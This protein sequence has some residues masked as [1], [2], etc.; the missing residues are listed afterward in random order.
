MSRSVPGIG[1]ALLATIAVAR[2]ESPQAP[3]PRAIPI[4]ELVRQLG[5]EDF[6]ERE[7]AAKRLGSLA[8]DPPSE[9]LAAA[10]SDIPEVRQRAIQ[11]TQAMRANLAATRLPRG[12]RFAEVGRVDLFVAATAEWNL[13]PEDPRLWEPAVDLGRR[14][15]TKADMKGDRKP[16]NCPSSFKDFATYKRFYGPRFTRAGEPYVCPDPQQEDPPRLLLNEAILAPGVVSP[17]GLPGDI[18]VS[19]GNVEVTRA[20]MESVVFA[21]GDV[22]ARNGLYSVVIVCDG[23]V[24]LTDS[25]TSKALIVARGNITIRGG[26][27]ASTLVAGGKVTL[28]EKR[29]TDAD[30]YNV[31]KENETNPLG[32][33]TFFELSTVGVEAKLADTAIKVTAVADGKPFAKAGVKAGDVITGVNGKKPDSAESLRRLL[34]DALAVGDATVTLRRG[35]KTETVKVA[36]PE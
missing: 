31:I 9:L 4:A 23:D 32:Y 34:R 3:P 15:I 10:K 11:A 8:L 7:A 17:V 5:S 1:L 29:R 33:V 6:A 36:L 13:Q 21:T 2:G 26:A 35:D 18:V 24:T 12:Q 14:L 28:G 16:H 20:I 19:R 30:L 25:S 27:E 22:T